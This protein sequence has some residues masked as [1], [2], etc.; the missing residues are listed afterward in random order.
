MKTEKKKSLNAMSKD[1]ENVRRL[2]ATVVSAVAWDILLDEK[3]CGSRG[4]CVRPDGIAVDLRAKDEKEQKRRFSGAIHTAFAGVIDAV[5]GE[6]L[7]WL[8]AERLAMKLGVSMEY[9]KNGTARIQ[10]SEVPAV[11]STEFEGLVHFQSILLRAN[12][13]AIDEV[14]R[15]LK[16]TPWRD[17]NLDRAKAPWKT[18]RQRGLIHVIRCDEK[19]RV[20]RVN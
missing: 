2:A 19:G 13:E 1:P 9:P 7:P 10:L 18:L 14:E 5:R 6:S 20:W 3:E 11:E 8:D 12:A 15:F 4:E 17:W 16:D